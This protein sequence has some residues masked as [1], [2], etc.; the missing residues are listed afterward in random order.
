MF[1]T[2]HAEQVGRHPHPLFAVLI[3]L[4]AVAMGGAAC[5]AD[6]TTGGSESSEPPDA[7]VPLIQLLEF[8]SDQSYQAA[9]EVERPDPEEPSASA[10]VE[11]VS[12][13][14]EALGI[15]ADNANVVVSHSP[16]AVRIDFVR[17]DEAV[18]LFDIDDVTYRCTSGPVSQTCDEI[19]GRDYADK[20]RPVGGFVPIVLAGILREVQDWKGAEVEVD[21]T[22]VEIDELPSTCATIRGVEPVLLGGASDIDE[23]ELCVTDDGVLARYDA[24]DVHAE[25]VDFRAGV[26]EDLLATPD[27]T[28]GQPDDPVLAVALEVDARLRALAS[29]EGEAQNPRKDRFLEQVEGENLAVR[30]VPSDDFEANGRLTVLTGRGAACLVVPASPDGE[31][32]A[33]RDVCAGFTAP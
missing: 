4:L 33:E 31:G 6:S 27:E 21:T 17:L 13:D 12:L 23:W 7:I 10:P 19:S 26:P 14:M 32:E 20:I 24:G 15:E 1:P 9:Y 3:G 22:P 5:S 30:L 29:L 28:D 11:E 18:A 16:E 2:V 25:L 8:G